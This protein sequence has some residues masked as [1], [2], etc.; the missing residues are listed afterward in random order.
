MTDARRVGERRLLTFAVLSQAS[1]S[2]ASWG[3]GALGPELR[4]EF[5]LSAAGLGALLGASFVG[6]AAVLVPAGGLVDRVGPRRPLIVGGL[7]SG[8]MLVLAGLAERVWLVGA[9]LLAFGLT[10]SFVAVAGTVSIFHG[11]D[12]GRRG[13]AL[14]VRQMAVSG[15]GLAAAVLLPVLAAV[16]GVRLALIGSGFLAAVFA[17]A[18]G[19]AS[20]SGP[21]ATRREA[22]YATGVLRLP[23]M[24]RLLAIA[25]AYV[26][27]LV[28]V[29]NF[30]VPAIRDEG[31]PR[32]VGSALFAIVSVA[33]MVGRLVWGRIADLGGGTRRRATLRDLGLLAAVGAGAYWLVG[34][35]GPAAQLPVM[36]VFAFG[37]MG[38]NGLLYL[39]AGE[40]A[41]PDRAGRAVGL[42][43]TMLFGGGAVAAIPLGFLADHAGFSALWPAAAALALAGVLLTHGLPHARG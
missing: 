6:N 40:L 4:T 42:M 5:G 33:A 21:L 20:T 14:G 36:L 9:L 19:L 2:I 16:G 18:F 29:L 34:P 37:A 3:L 17:T 22:P 41:G 38:G 25:F 1:I 13:M 8:V 23:G 32:G 10:S 31:A 24:G 12:S 11:F 39:M 7:S 35:L 43:S 15:G 28:A 30:S 26:S 27:V